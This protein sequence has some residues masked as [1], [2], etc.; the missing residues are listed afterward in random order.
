MGLDSCT[1]V[2]SSDVPCSFKLCDHS[3]S[4][5]VVQHLQVAFALCGPIE[6]EVQPH[7]FFWWIWFPRLQRQ[8]G[9]LISSQMPLCGGSHSFKAWSRGKPCRGQKK[10]DRDGSSQSTGKGS[11]LNIFFVRHVPRMDN[12]VANTLSHKQIN[13]L[14][15]LDPVSSKNAAWN[16]QFLLAQQQQQ[17]SY[18]YT[19]GIFE[20]SQYEVV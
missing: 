10:Q 19:V 1:A 5:H 11:Q 15:Q 13:R 9:M 18:E 3:N 2:D 12:W 14:Q 6:N 4:G 17:K 7:L 8:K 20:E 16:S